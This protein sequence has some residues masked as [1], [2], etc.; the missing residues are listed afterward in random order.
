VSQFQ[1]ACVPTSW[2]LE[3]AMDSF[4][5]PMC[6]SNDKIVCRCLQISEAS[7][8]KALENNEIRSVFDIRRLTG[9]GDGCTCCH[10]LLEEYLRAHQRRMLRPLELVG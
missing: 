6:D 8:L 3:I 4:S 1:E 5:L 9:A 7:I 10:A 2:A